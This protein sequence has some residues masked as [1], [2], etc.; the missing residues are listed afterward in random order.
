MAKITKSK[1]INLGLCGRDLP[2]IE[3]VPPNSMERD[4]AKKLK[5]VEKN[6]K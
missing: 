5:L 2:A 3:L 6:Y 1:D 4:P